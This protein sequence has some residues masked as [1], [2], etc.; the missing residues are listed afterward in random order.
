MHQVPMNRYAYYLTPQ[1]LSEKSLLTAEYLAVSL[2]FF[3]RARTDCAA[4]YRQCEASGWHS[5][6]LYAEAV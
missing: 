3:R 4:L 5:V 6:A 2:D 1:G